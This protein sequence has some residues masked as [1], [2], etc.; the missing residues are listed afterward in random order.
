MGSIA[1]TKNFTANADGTTTVT[2][3]NFN[4]QDNWCGDNKGSNHGKK[5]VIKF[6]IRP[7][8]KQQADWTFQRTPRTP[9]SMSI[10]K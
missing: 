10:M 7:A 3:S 1:A 5:L 4:F 2:V 9:V 6:P 8:R